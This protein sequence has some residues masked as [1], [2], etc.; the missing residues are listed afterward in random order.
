MEK[1]LIAVSLVLAGIL[2]PLL[3]LLPLH[4][5][6]RWVDFKIFS[7]FSRERERAILEH[8]KLISEEHGHEH[9]LCVIVDCIGWAKYSPALKSRV[10]RRIKA[11]L[12]IPKSVQTSLPHRDM[13][14]VSTYQSWLYDVERIYGELSGVR[15]S[16]HLRQLWLERWIEMNNRG[17][18]DE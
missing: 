7:K 9:Y 3:L 2:L 5:W 10:K 8:L 11:S 16:R 13:E 18:S 4:L 6:Y 17:I 15:D 12:S 14:H 1:L